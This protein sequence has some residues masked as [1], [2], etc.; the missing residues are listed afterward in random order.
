MTIREL[1]TKWGFD[2]DEKPI[3]ALDN[4]IDRVKSNFT[5][6]TA[7]AG[8]A[9]TTIFGF[10]AS[11]SA[12]GD[13]IAKTSRKLNVSARDYQR[14]KF[15][16]DQ[17][18]VSHEAFDTGL[19][20]FIGTVGEAA[21]GTGEATKIFQGLGIQVRGANGQIRPTEAL[22]GEF[23]DRFAAIPDQAAKSAL[24]MKLFGRDGATM[25]L[26][27]NEGAAG[28]AKMGDEAEALGNVLSADTLAAAE[29]LNDRINEGKQ[30]VLGWKNAIGAE[31]MPIVS[32]VI[33]AFRSWSIRNRE[34][35]RTKIH[36]YVKNFVAA[37]KMLLG[38]L[39][40]LLNSVLRVISFMLRFRKILSAV[41]ALF[42]AW[43]ALQFA[44]A[45]GEIARV[46]VTTLL[47][48]LLK[49]GKATS[50]VA[51]RS[52]AIT[53]AWGAL[54]VMLG[55]IIE[56]VIT[57]FE[58]GDSVLGRMMKTIDEWL[59]SI[60]NRIANWWFG[61][62][63]MIT[64]STLWKTLQGIG[65]Q[66]NSM[67]SLLGFGGD[68]RPAYAGIGSGASVA[69]TQNNTFQVPDEKTAKLVAGYTAQ[70][71]SDMLKEAAR[72]VSKNPNRGT[73]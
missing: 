60:A 51:I 3:K 32:R 19:K 5:Y 26:F 48:M 13:E 64:E 34:L 4:A 41:V 7:A 50:W 31:L 45:L 61:I 43:K 39:S 25:S 69:L 10:A 73:P 2:I 58:G 24:A 11:T 47:P 44:H 65:F 8:G 68:N 56:D 15:A 12:A 21:A 57:F 18:G 35:I 16:A 9:V 23:A 30:V 55:L 70:F 20:R 54:I 36:I 72:H 29:D 33:V 37:T 46:G 17:A 49:M 67:A 28:L 1:V 6:L 66:V 27:L 38:V 62:E 14:L 63:M 59:D 42:V 40:L 53:A 22:L 71:N 52:W